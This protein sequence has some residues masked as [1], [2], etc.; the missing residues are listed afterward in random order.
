MK[1]PG[2]VALLKQ[3]AL[4]SP[5]VTVRCTN[6]HRTTPKNPRWPILQA[7]FKPTV[8]CRARK[9]RWN[10]ACA[11]SPGNRSFMWIASDIWSGTR[12]A[13]ALLLRAVEERQSSFHRAARGP[14]S[15]CHGAGLQVASERS[16]PRCGLVQAT[17]ICPHLSNSCPFQGRSCA[18]RHHRNAA[19]ILFQDGSRREGCCSA[20]P[21]L[22]RSGIQRID[23]INASRRTCRRLTT[24]I[25]RWAVG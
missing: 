5:M 9:Q 6:R 19:R 2:Q 23:H 16:R 21:N 22:F 17:A 20:T 4:R 11:T 18:L 13:A 7:E 14:L 25:P 12:S 10:L 8:Q 24:S 1:I 15:E 3:A